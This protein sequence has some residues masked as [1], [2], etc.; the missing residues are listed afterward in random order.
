M[1]EMVHATIF[2]LILTASTKHESVAEFFRG[3]DVLQQLQEVS[4]NNKLLAFVSS[5]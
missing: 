3:P 2:A 4:K 5:M 1:F